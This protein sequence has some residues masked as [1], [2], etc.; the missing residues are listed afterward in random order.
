MDTFL[1][2]LHEVRCEG[3][4]CLT[5]LD[6]GLVFSGALPVLSL[7]PS[8]ERF[9]AAEEPTL[10]APRSVADIPGEEGETDAAQGT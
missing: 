10:P 8:W 2:N 6:Q 7:S 1:K 9:R 4:G 3:Q 5:S